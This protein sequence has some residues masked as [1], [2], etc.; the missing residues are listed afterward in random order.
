MTNTD[1]HQNTPGYLMGC[2]VCY[3][4]FDPVGEVVPVSKTNR[5]PTLPRKS[6][7]ALLSGVVF[8]VAIQIAAFWFL[9]F[10]PEYG[11]RLARLGER[12]GEQ[13]GRPVVIV[14]G[15]S[16]VAMGV[17]P[18]FVGPAMDGQ[19][20]VVFNYGLVGSGPVMQLCCVKRLLA[21]GICPD[22]VLVEY[23]PA[24]WLQ[25]G[26]MREQE[27][28]DPTRLR[29]ADLSL[30]RGYLRINQL[31]RNWYTGRVVPWFSGRF[32]VLSRHVPAWAPN[33][34]RLD[35]TWANL[36]SFGWLPNTHPHTGE[37]GY[38]QRL[39][40]F[41]AI[42]EPVLRDF[43]VSTASDRALRELIAVC[44]EHRIGVAILRMPESTDFQSWYPPGVPAEV[45]DYLRRVTREQGVPVIDARTW[46]PDDG[47][48]DGFHL[49]P[50][51]AAQLTERL[52]REAILPLLRSRRAAYH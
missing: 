52:G 38:R 48:S 4:F 28:I 42:Y 10:D 51:A 20:P 13:P 47:F 44:E 21:D 26:A 49:Y 29:R 27:R 17:R 34:A 15:S 18:E 22:C 35:S 23:W 36:S 43:K 41:R 39:K 11:D 50:E 1:G 45:D 6:R 2:Y 46:V 40:H 31:R 32:V 30:I 16:R 5:N 7:L 37:A 25:D 19:Q 8:F 14:L 12:I 3:H 24:F 9:E 33:G